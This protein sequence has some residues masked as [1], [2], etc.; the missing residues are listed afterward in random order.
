MTF[1][2]KLGTL[3]SLPATKSPCERL[4]HF[5]IYILEICYQKGA[6]PRAITV[7]RDVHGKMR[8]KLIFKNCARYGGEYEV[9]L[10]SMQSTLIKEKQNKRGRKKNKG[11]WESL[12]NGRV[13]RRVTSYKY[14]LA[15]PW[16]S[17]T[18]VPDAGRIPSFM[19]DRVALPRWPALNRDSV[20]FYCFPPRR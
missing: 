16:V 17:L 14:N 5:F 1:F 20:L 6:F 7:S 15:S 18:D 4:L 2:S 13:L 11:N 10:I 9:N 12:S 8:F 19:G 3:R